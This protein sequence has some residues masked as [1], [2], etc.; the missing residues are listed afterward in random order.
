M[1]YLEGYPNVNPYYKLR[2]YKIQ[3]YFQKTKM[4]HHLVMDM[5]DMKMN[6]TSDGIAFNSGTY[7]IS[8]DIR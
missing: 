7:I 2:I 1:S 6:N 5:N 3:T 4:C 8:G